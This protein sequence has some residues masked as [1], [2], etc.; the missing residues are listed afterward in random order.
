MQECLAA[1]TP[2]EEALPLFASAFGLDNL[3][4]AETALMKEAYI[5]TFYQNAPGGNDEEYGTYEP[6]T[7][8]CI[9]IV[10]A[11]AGVRFGSGGTR[12]KT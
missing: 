9:D 1:K 3:T 7:T 11:R 12:P 10:A 8:T 5:K 2:F 4:D 6:I